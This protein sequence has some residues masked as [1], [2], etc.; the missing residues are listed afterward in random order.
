VYERTLFNA[1]EILSTGTCPEQ[2]REG[3]CGSTCARSSETVSGVG[4]NCNLV[5]ST[6]DFKRTVG[7]HV[8]ICYPFLRVHSTGVV[9]CMDAGVDSKEAESL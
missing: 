6:G 9:P 7:L 1:L 5:A 8:S 4:I 2:L 3:D